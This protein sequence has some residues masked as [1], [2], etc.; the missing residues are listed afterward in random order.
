MCPRARSTV[1]G[2]VFA[3]RSYGPDARTAAGA[4]DPP[5]RE[6]RRVGPPSSST[7]S[8]GTAVSSRWTTAE[9]A[10][11]P[12]RSAARSRHGGPTWS[13]SSA[14]SG[15]TGST[16]FGLS[17]GGMVAQAL[18]TQAPGLVD[19]LIA[20][21][22]GPAGGP[23]LTRMTGV[24]T[25]SILRAVAT[26][27]DPKDAAVL[28]PHADRAAAPPTT[29]SPGSPS[30]PRTGSAP[31]RR[32]VPGAADRGPKWGA[33]GTGRP[34]RT[35]GP[36]LIVHGDSDRMVPPANADALARPACRAPPSRSSR[37]PGTASSSRTTT[38]F[39]AA[40]RDFLRR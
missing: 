31:S 35:G 29:T 13:R 9:S 36:V 17:M 3:Y 8:P 23:G 39:V 12:A 20:A 7:A 11:P 32:G 19:G 6:P 30:A 22:S 27:T 33:V 40:A 38:A 5:G 25:R 24:M 15:S 2:A 10:A 21:G 4:V 26:F 34:A 18:V 1:G 16:C 14:R 28:H 37:I